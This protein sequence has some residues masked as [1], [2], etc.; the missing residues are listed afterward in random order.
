LIEKWLLNP[1]ILPYGFVKL[2]M[3]RPL[4]VS[5]DIN[6]A[7]KGRSLGRY[8]SLRPRSSVQVFSVLIMLVLKLFDVESE[9]NIV[10]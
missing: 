4:S 6:F 7:N 3:W 10:V 9:S 8:S 1:R 2:T 5:V